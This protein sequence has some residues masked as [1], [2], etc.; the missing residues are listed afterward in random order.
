MFIFPKQR[1]AGPDDGWEA[2]RAQCGFICLFVYKI[3]LALLY[4]RLRT[5]AFL[6]PRWGTG[7][8]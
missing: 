1:V 5:D 6:V 4:R 7:G 8:R 2:G 3:R